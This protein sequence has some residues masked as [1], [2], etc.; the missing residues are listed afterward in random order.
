M[1]A[2]TGLAFPKGGSSQTF[3]GSFSAPLSL[4]AVAAISVLVEL[5]LRFDSLVLKTIS[6]RTFFLSLVRPPISSSSIFQ[7]VFAPSTSALNLKQFLRFSLSF[8]SLYLAAFFF[9]SNNCAGTLRFLHSFVVIHIHFWYPENA[10]HRSTIAL[11]LF[12]NINGF[13]VTLGSL[14]FSSWLQQK[15][16]LQIKIFK[17]DSFDAIISSAFVVSTVTSCWEAC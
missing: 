9:S 5:H 2:K 6:L 7:R 14:I 11:S 12:M 1:E 13:I 8:Y 10:Q 17:L 3:H 15:S 16:L 4:V